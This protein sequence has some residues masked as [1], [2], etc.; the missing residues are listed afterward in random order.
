MLDT[1]HQ[2]I[3]DDVS[4]TIRTNINTANHH[5]IVEEVMIYE[6]DK[7]TSSNEAG[8][9]R[10]GMGGGY[11]TEVTRQARLAEA[12]YKM[13]GIYARLLPATAKD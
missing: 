4:C 3:H 11:M 6:Q 2:Q 13:E 10:I 5:F 7:N 9:H 8:V 1:Y 12:E